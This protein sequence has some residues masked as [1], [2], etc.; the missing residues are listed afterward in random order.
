L[1]QWLESQG[2]TYIVTHD[3]EPS[4][5]ELDKHLP[6][7]DILITTPFHPAYITKE[8]FEKAKNLKLAI[9]AGVGSDHIDLQ[10]CRDQQHTVSVL[11]VTG[12]S[13]NL[14]PH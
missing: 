3:K 4:D 9:T 6:D 10:Y 2:H 8:R 1:R 11:E 13:N 7:T 5:S 12:K 14:L